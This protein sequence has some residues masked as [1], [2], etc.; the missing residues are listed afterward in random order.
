MGTLQFYIY[1]LFSRSQAP[2]HS[3]IHKGNRL[4][5]F[6]GAIP[7]GCPLRLGNENKLEQRGNLPVSG[8]HT[9]SQAPASLP[10]SSRMEYNESQTT[11]K[12]QS[13]EFERPPRF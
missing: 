9:R 2:A 1:S 4:S 3:L 6:V 7:C 13:V 8:S 10:L 11:N 12:K 5:L